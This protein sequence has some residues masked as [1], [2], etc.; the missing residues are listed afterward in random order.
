MLGADCQVFWGQHH[1]SVA[2]PAEWAH[3]EHLQHGLSAD[4][5]VVWG[6]YRFL[7]AHPAEWA[8]AHHAHLQC[9]C[10]GAGYQVVWGQTIR[11]FGGR[12]IW[13]AGRPRQQLGAGEATT[14]SARGC[15]CDMC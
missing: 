2:Y 9:G 5:Q 15:S 11:W 14:C 4:Y 6:Q 3:H 8:C 13:R 12:L 10:L 1:S 7:V